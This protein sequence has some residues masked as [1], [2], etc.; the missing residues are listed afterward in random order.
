MAKDLDDAVKEY[1]MVAFSKQYKA[2]DKARAKETKEQIEAQR[3]EK[4]TAPKPTGVYSDFTELFDKEAY[5]AEKKAVVEAKKQAEADEAALKEAKRQ[6]KNADREQKLSA[7]FD[8]AIVKR[9][10]K[11]E[12][13]ALGNESLKENKER[14][15][16]EKAAAKAER[17]A[18]A[19]APKPV[20][21]YDDF[22]ELFDKAAYDV[23]KAAEAAVV[24]EAKAKV[25][26]EK[27]A[28]RTEKAEKHEAK[29]SDKYDSAVEK[30]IAKAEK[31]A[32]LKTL[33]NESIKEN[34]D[35]KAAE[36]ATEKAERL[37]K[38]NAPKPVVI[39]DDFTELF[40]KEAYDAEK[41]AE[42]AAVAEAKAKVQA[43]KD[44]KRHEKAEK[45]DAKDIKIYEKETAETLEANAR[46]QEMDA[47]RKQ[48]KAE[49]KAR[50]K[51]EK[52]KA[53][54]ERLAKANAPKPEVIYP[55]PEFIFGDVD[56]ETKALMD[57]TLED[58][59][60]GA[61]PKTV[62]VRELTRAAKE[63]KQLQLLIKKDKG[64]I[65]RV[66]HDLETLELAEKFVD[67][68]AIEMADAKTVVRDAKQF[69]KDVKDQRVIKEYNKE[70][71]RELEDEEKLRLADEYKRTLA[72]NKK[73]VKRAKKYGKFMLEYGSTYDPE[74]DGE[75]NNYG[76]PEVHPYT[77]G[78][79]L[80]PSRRRTPKKEKLSYF[81]KNNL[82][83]LAREQCDT[84][85]KM[86][87]ARVEYDYTALEL[88]VNKFAQDF[89][90]EFKGKK[91]KRW[92]RQSKN[93]LKTFKAKLASALKYEKLDNER[94]YSVVAT[95][96][97]RA[98]LPDKA[99]RDELIAMREELMRLLDIRDEINGELI[100]LYTG[101]DGAN[102]SNIKGRAKVTL[103]ARKRAHVSFIRYFRVLNKRRVT[104]N[105]KMRIFDKMDEIVELK[106]DIAKIRYI[107]R[108]EKPTGKVKRDYQK[109][110]NR[111][112]RDV[113]I[114]KKS[115][116]RST[117]KALKKAKKR[118]VRMWTM[119]FAYSIFIALALFVIAMVTMGPEIL[120][121]SKLL[122]PENLHQYVD[123][124]LNNWPL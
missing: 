48:Y 45:Q 46:E 41:A 14:K 19:N 116:E 79:K 10:K 36:K 91:E 74:W 68:G 77:E 26:A 89:S 60:E 63:D 52:A 27:E 124:L 113:R 40:D 3:L 37:A 31:K 82:S 118:E 90:G 54:A 101:S 21:I 30:A 108:K 64:T 120:R 51:E 78:V 22:T 115:V 4:L 69:D 103:K 28:K 11:D 47:F 67:D 56:V 29:M 119:I 7:N 104:R 23:D 65:K 83:A 66:K 49:A 33:G 38:K 94:Y 117:L 42:A 5:D 32:E 44:A 59:H 102:K 70:I 2:E 93:K 61:R 111:A 16:A 114:L 6:E 62:T 84:D 20:V 121:A 50:A 112:K 73:R 13:K 35:R 86:I 105:E 106:G 1:E 96:F 17:I 39:Y 100:E 53:E 8:A 98:E 107:L 97:A 88:E 95:D 80:A 81:N 92:F 12:L 57:A 109:E 110:L 55:D 122:L 76:L 9:D 24:A 43:E 75:F 58:V 25:E 87:E 123:W 71:A 85:L 99:D 15:A 34:K 18:K 72:K